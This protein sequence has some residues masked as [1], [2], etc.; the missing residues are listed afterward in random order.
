M[1]AEPL[2]N[3]NDNRSY[4]DLEFFSVR[5]FQDE[6]K[7]NSTLALVR[8]IYRL[9]KK[10]RGKGR[11]KVLENILA[12]HFNMQDILA[13]G[14]FNLTD[15]GFLYSLL[16][17]AFKDRSSVKK[18]IKWSSKVEIAYLQSDYK[19]LFSDLRRHYEN[20][21][22]FNPTIA[23]VYG[24]CFTAIRN[25]I[26]QEIFN[27]Y[28]SLTIEAVAQKTGFRNIEIEMF[29]KENPELPYLFDPITQSVVYYQKSIPLYSEAETFFRMVQDKYEAKEKM[30]IED[31]REE[32]DLEGFEERGS[33][34]RGAGGLMG[35]MGGFG[36]L[37]GRGM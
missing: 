37:M 2:K 18:H 23:F 21:G 5:S 22:C 6:K 26:F 30:V 25:R 20:F 36:S 11:V 7:I 17:L 14:I 16:V 29:I 12:P 10:G 33:R 28:E 1:E 13:N 4:Q 24:E 35:A 8:D 31:S 15:L 34:R 3:S 32:F 9:S 27:A 19:K